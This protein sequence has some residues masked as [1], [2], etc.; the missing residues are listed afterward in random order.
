MKS[1]S[2]LPLQSFRYQVRAILSKELRSALPN[3]KQPNDSFLR[4]NDPV[5]PI[6]EMYS[7]RLRKPPRD[8]EYEC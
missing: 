5:F 8:I 6:V 1:R 3:G 4:L 2:R 7:Q